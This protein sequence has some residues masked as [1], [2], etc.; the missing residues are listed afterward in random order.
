[1]QSKNLLDKLERVERKI[2][3]YD[4]KTENLVSEVNIDFIPLERLK[5]V[6]IPIEG[7]VQLYRPYELNTK[8]LE[9]LNKDLAG[10]IKADFGMYYYVLECDA[11][12]NW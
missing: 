6:V 2:N 12:Y 9:E 10:L 7:D 5:S 4:I 8:Q 11:I 3:I 1:M